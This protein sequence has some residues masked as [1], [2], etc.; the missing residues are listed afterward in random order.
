MGP[1]RH[2]AANTAGR[3]RW[4][5]SGPDRG[6]NAAVRSPRRLRLR[7]RRADPPRSTR[8]YGCTVAPPPAWS[9]PEASPQ[10]GP[11][12][13][14]ED[15][16]RASGQARDEDP[17]SAVGVFMTDLA[18]V[19]RSST[20][21]TTSLPADLHVDSA[22]DI[23]SA[24]TSEARAP[25]Q[26]GGRA[27]SGVRSASRSCALTGASAFA[28]VARTTPPPT[29]RQTALSLWRLDVATARG[30]SSLAPSGTSQVSAPEAPLG[31]GRLVASTSIRAKPASKPV[32]TARHALPPTTPH[33]AARV[34]AR[35]GCH[36]GLV[37]DPDATLE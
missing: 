18:A 5:G 32:I 35:G 30:S 8:R 10:R 1:Q 11:A 2:P 3:P 37:T 12:R 29:T 36:V 7:A 15:P 17:P 22:T 21:P 34:R 31:D 20:E 28:L 24:K 9:A 25:L 33:R 4:L 6:R 23:D 26:W 27:S 19:V 14:V 16:A 13:Q